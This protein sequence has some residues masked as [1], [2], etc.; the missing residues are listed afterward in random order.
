[1]NANQALEVKN[2][3]LNGLYRC[4]VY[5]YVFKKKNQV[6]TMEKKV[7]NGSKKIG[8]DPQLSF[9]RLVTAGVNSGEPKEVFQH[10][11]YSY[12]PAL[13]ESQHAILEANKDALANSI[14]KGL[15]MK[16]PEL[17]QQV[18]YVRD[19]MW[20]KPGQ[21]YAPPIQGTFSA[22]MDVFT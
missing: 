11:P 15:P 12:P 6:L 14:W 13:F 3:I 16:D 21:Q 4:D 1:M 22:T 9:Q 20:V 18:T 7:S 19:G 8:I 2:Q 17:P 10:E 5:D